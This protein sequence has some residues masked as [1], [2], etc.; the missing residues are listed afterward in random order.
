MYF[1]DSRKN[2]EHPSPKQRY[3]FQRKEENNIKRQARL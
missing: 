2:L 3:W 1:G